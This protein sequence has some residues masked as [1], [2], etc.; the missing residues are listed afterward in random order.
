MRPEMPLRARKF[1]VLRCQ[2]VQSLEKSVRHKHQKTTETDVNM[3]LD[4]W[5][6][7]KSEDPDR[8]T[9]SLPDL[10]SRNET[11]RHMFPGKLQ[12]LP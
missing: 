7:V 1:C 2:K 8:M 4:L 9:C 10:L 3:D 11:R 12:V 6:R 5:Q